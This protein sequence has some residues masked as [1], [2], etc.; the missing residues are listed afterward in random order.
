MIVH[1]PLNREG[2]ALSFKHGVLFD[3]DGVV[4]MS[5]HV[6]A[7]AHSATIAA[8]GGEVPAPFYANIMGQSH[9]AV[10]AAFIAASGRAID[11][12]AYSELYQKVLHERMLT[13]VRVAHGVL[14]LLARLSSAGYAL[15]LVTSSIRWM[16]DLSLEL[17]ATEPFFHAKIC[18]DDVQRTK[19]AP[20]PY[21]LALA[22]LRLPAEQ[23]VVF[24]DSQTGITAA[25]AAGL[26]VIAIRH[27]FNGSHDFAAADVVLDTLH[28]TESV[29]ETI[30]SVLAK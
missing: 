17:T 9:Q 2:V 29:V 10:R 1:E 5:E 3:L 26:P 28:D 6:K 7:Q 20:E 23:A 22:K 14:A 19:P 21:L 8:Y 11:P 25:K 12:E 16:M 4:V 13:G 27:P 18:A 30:E 24:E 15:A